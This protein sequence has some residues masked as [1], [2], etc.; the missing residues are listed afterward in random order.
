MRRW[1][2]T[3][4]PRSAIVTPKQLTK[5]LL[6]TAFVLGFAL[7]SGVDFPG[8][9]AELAPKQRSRVAT[10]WMALHALYLVS[11]ITVLWGDQRI[12]TLHPVSLRGVFVG[13]GAILAIAAVVWM[14]AVKDLYS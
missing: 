11:I 1:G 4:E 7:A 8:G 5:V 14:L 12:G 13:V 6:L 3:G 2:A 10:L 9:L